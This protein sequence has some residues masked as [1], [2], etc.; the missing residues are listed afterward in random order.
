MLGFFGCFSCLFVASVVHADGRVFVVELSNSSSFLGFREAEQ[1]CASQQA[2]LASAAELRHAVMECF[3]SLCTRGWLH[4]GTVGTTVCNYVGGSLKAVDVRT[5]N[6]TGDS[7][8]VNGFCIKD[9]GVPCGDPPSFPNTRLQG[10]SGFELG[11]ELL[12]ACVPGY[13]MPNGH[14]AFSLLCDSCG[15]WYGLVQMCVKDSTEGHVDY[16]DK[17]TYGGTV[18]A[19]GQVYE[20]AH[21]GP[22]S[23]EPWGQELQDM[24]FTVKG[25]QP[26]DYG[27]QELEDVD[28]REEQALEDSAGHPRR[29]EDRREVTTIPTEAP[30]SLLSQ[31]HRFWF[32]SETFQQQEEHLV[33]VDPITHNPQRPSGGQ[34]KESREEERRPHH[35]EQD[36][37]ERHEDDDHQGQVEQHITYEELDDRSR[38][39]DR[40]DDHYDMG[41]HEEERVRYDDQHDTDE[42]HEDDVT[43]DGDDHQE[44]L[45]GSEERPDQDDHD[46]NKDNKD[47]DD[48]FDHVDHDSHEDHTD[49]DDRDDHDNP[50]DHDDQEDHDQHEDHNDPEDHDDQEDQDDRDDHDDD[51]S[52]H[53]DH[54]DHMNHND[55]DDHDHHKDHKDHYEDTDDNDDF[56]DGRKDDNDSYENHDSHEDHH[57]NDGHQRV[58]FSTT[59]DRTQNITRGEPGQVATTDDSWLDGHPVAVEEG[60]VGETVARAT[61]NP[62]EVEKNI[63]EEWETPAPD[64]PAS[65][66]D[67][68]SSLEYDTQQV[69]P[70]HSWLLDLTQHP[71][72]HHGPAHEDNVVEHT[73]PDLPGETSE[74]GKVEGEA[75]ETICVGESCPP[76]SS[77]SRGPIVAAI[78][79]AVCLVAAAVVVT[80]WCYRQRQQKS[81]VYEMNGKGQSSQQM[82]MQQKV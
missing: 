47:L 46:D 38:H 55:H 77:N 17:F 75:G 56:D 13:V 18:E 36:S 57:D 19:H 64:N 40:H 11:D 29:E 16:E 6:A 35:Q 41:E 58:V 24:S 53:D 69:V 72:L 5:E 27:Q 48:H 12:Y 59:R 33:S 42:E 34:S 81:S 37:D 70:T 22:Q 68:A 49:H 82:E 61:D 51:H 4:G 2:R 39:K 60:V 14:S 8:Q 9:K 15:E 28:H 21:G 50:E 76:P 26:E 43:H 31:K 23:E 67:S 66:S 7:T 52:D 3:F 10:H 80:V 1:A 73:L 44:Q 74:R 63:P 62:N 78:I 45:D 25:E 20:E 71:F 65:S 32:P 54:L 30:V 79:A